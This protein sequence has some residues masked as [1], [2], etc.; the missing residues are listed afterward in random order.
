[1]VMTTN[2]LDWPTMALGIVEADFQVV[3]PPELAER[4][5]EWGARF[6]RA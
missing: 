5:R 4:V 1:M 3:H 6:Q 2:S